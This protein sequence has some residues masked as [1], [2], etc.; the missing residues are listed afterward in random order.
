[1]ILIANDVHQNLDICSDD[2]VVEDQQPVVRQKAKHGQRIQDAKFGP[3]EMA[4]EEE[5][6]SQHG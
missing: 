4:E 5:E 2:L 1:M 3:D 6:E